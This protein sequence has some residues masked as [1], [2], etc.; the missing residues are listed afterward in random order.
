MHQPYTMMLSGMVN[1]LM[2]LRKALRSPPFSLHF[3]SYHGP[4]AG[5]VTFNSSVIVSWYL[6]QPSYLKVNF[7]GSM[8]CRTVLYRS[9][10]SV[11]Y[12]TGWV[13]VQN[14]SLDQHRPHTALYHPYRS[15][16]RCVPTRT[17]VYQDKK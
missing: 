15:M 3:L 12:C 10:W 14:S 5:Y 16:T 6:L 7:G 2:G 13:P 8:D 11:P 17:K 4:S 1:I 9:I